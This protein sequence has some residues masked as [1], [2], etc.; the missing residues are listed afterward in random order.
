MVVLAKVLWGAAWE[1][2]PANRM[3][4]LRTRIERCVEGSRTQGATGSRSNYLMWVTGLWP[5]GC[6]YFF[7]A[8]NAIGGEKWRVAVNAG[9][10]SHRTLPTT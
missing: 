3:K 5:A 2:A 9:A 4:T 8:K 7:A 1:R 10:L 6:S